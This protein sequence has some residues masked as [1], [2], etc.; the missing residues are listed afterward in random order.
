MINKEKNCEECGKQFEYQFND[1]GNYPDKRKY[2]DGCSASKKASWEASK[3]QP[4]QTAPLQSAVPTLSQPTA[5]KKETGEFQKTVWE[6][7]VAQNSYSVGKAESRHKFYYETMD[8]LK[9]KMLEVGLNFDA[10]VENNMAIGDVQAL[11]DQQEGF[12]L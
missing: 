1:A 10:M 11:S 5:V 6:H 12:V 9:A 2:C 3:N 8:E 4:A 7:K